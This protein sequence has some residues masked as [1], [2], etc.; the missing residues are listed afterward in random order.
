V[1]EEV[2]LR[3]VDLTFAYNSEYILT[4]ENFSVSGAGLIT[5]LGPNGA[6]KTT[7]FKVLMG[8]LKPVE[9]KVLVNGLE[10]TGNPLAAGRFMS[11]VPQISNIEFGY[12]ITGRELIEATLRS[13]RR[14]KDREC[15]SRAG[16]YLKAVKA[17]EF[18]D[19]R[20]SELS[21]GQLQRILIARALARETPILLLDEPFSGVDPRAREDI[22]SFIQRI[23]REKMVLLTT[24]DPVLTI[25]LSRYIIVFNRGIKAVGSPRDIFK[26]DMLR[27][28]YGDGVLLI[29]KCLHV[30]A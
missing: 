28:A 24:H 7:F 20:L 25:N 6:G 3:V 11:Y 17:E 18:A 15:R 16:E 12:P 27:K 13:E 5:V 22:L 26:L 2:E 4:K 21:G 14:C 1:H 9:G 8:L 30:I 23:S 10:V 29:E 19:K